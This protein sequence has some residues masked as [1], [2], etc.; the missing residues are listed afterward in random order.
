[1]R[2]RRTR[3]LSWLPALLV[4]ALACQRGPS[5]ETQ[6]RM[7]ELTAAAQE[8]DRLVQEVAENTRLLSEISAELT[9][10][11][12]PA[13]TLRGVSTESPLRASRDTMIRKVRYISAR[14]GEVENRLRES[15]QRIEQL[16]TISD[17]LRTTLEET[18]RNFEGIVQ[19]QLATIEALKQ[20]VATLESEKQALSDTLSQVAARANR[21]YYVVGT[22][23]ELKEQGLVVEEGGSRFLFVLWKQG[24][25]LQPARELDP[26]KFTA[27]DRREV[28]EIHL[29][30]PTATYRIASRQDLDYLEAPISEDG[31]I[32]GTETLRITDSERF[33][34]PSR[35]LI[36]V[37]EGGNGGPTAAS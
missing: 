9:K 18:Q 16:T 27:I 13:R 22:K 7:E 31:R 19:N 23:D 14:I 6:A 12:V 24:E 36:I 21:V 8:R 32:R 3:S 2:T 37:K 5:Q 10:V 17:S 4:A 29:P 35:F 11:Q 26:S 1:M 34:L 33:W 15:R 20:Q 25:T 28:T 30:D